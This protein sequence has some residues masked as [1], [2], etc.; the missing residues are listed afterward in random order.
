MLI[1]RIPGYLLSLTYHRPAAPSGEYSAVGYVYKEQEIEKAQEQPAAETAQQQTAPI[2]EPELEPGE[3]LES[4]KEK[5]IEKEEKKEKEKTKEKDKKKQKE[6]YQL[7][8]R[9]EKTLNQM[10][11]HF[12]ISD[13]CYL[14]R[15]DYREREQYR[16]A[17]QKKI[18]LEQESHTHLPGVFIEVYNFVI[19]QASW[20]V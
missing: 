4:E 5:K 20:P 8:P 15:I 16:E 17:I 3:I 13:Y 9:T 19:L 1:S 6:I 14:G 18:K 11:E 10:A 12:G 7:S 2:N